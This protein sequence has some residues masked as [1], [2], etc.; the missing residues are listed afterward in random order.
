MVET[1]VLIHFITQVNYLIDEAVSIGKGANCIISLVHH[2]LSHH[3]FGECRIVLHADNCSGQNKNRFFMQYFAWRVLAGL[4]TSIEISFMLVGHTKFAPDW[5]FG[6]LK[7]RFRRTKVGCLADLE[8]VVNT[9]AEVNHA[10][11]VGKEDG[12][13]LVPQYDWAA[14]FAPY[15]KRQ[16]FKGIKSLRHLTFSQGTPGS[17]MVRE[18]TDSQENQIS[19]LAKDHLHWA[20]SSSDL[21]PEMKPPGLSRERKEYLYSKIREYCPPECQDIV[22]PNPNPTIMLPTTP[23]TQPTQPPPQ[24]RQRT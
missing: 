4:N 13:V 20:P 11:L 10:Q 7:Q 2:F 3:N 19:I 17:V 14:Y 24:K 9:S 6:L 15:Y 21:P 8:K 22:C 5:C 18:Y 23:L 12:T 16:A 1:Q